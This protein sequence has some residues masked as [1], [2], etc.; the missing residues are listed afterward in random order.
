MNCNVIEELIYGL[1]TNREK[2]HIRISVCQIDVDKY[3]SVFVELCYDG[4]RGVTAVS[5][6]FPYSL[7]LDLILD[8]NCPKRFERAIRQ[9]ELRLVHKINVL[10][11]DANRQGWYSRNV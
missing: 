2:D 9:F 8:E 3:P 1:L 7:F 5:E 6:Q 4:K 10:P 11:I